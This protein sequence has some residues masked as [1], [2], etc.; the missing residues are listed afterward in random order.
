MS[1]PQGG[2]GFGPNIALIYWVA[3]ILSKC[4]C[5][6]DT[7]YGYLHCTVFHNNFIMM[8]LLKIRK[9]AVKK[10]RLDSVLS[11]LNN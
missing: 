2:L 4:S 7:W 6:I 8:I 10:T 9:I 1:D 5:R 3:F 11:N